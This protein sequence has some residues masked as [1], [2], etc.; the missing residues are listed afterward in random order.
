M[1]WQTDFLVEATAGLLGVFIGVVA[2]LWAERRR[3][4]FEQ[5]RESVRESKELDDVRHAVLASVVK[6][7]L[8]VTRLKASLLAR[9]DPYLLG[10]H[11]EGAVWEATQTHFVRVASLDDGILFSRFF[12]QV[13]RLN[14]LLDFFRE[15]RADEGLQAKP[16]QPTSVSAAIADRLSEVAEDVKLEG[17]VIVID[18]GDHT[19]KQLLGLA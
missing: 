4:N 3:A 18:H 19:Q 16:A 5:K 17:V 9:N 13:R 11:F 8:E 15:A 12:D 1:A 14:Q 7:T 6:N 10:V 2:A